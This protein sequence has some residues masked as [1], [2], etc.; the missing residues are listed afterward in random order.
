ME[1]TPAVLMGLLAEILQPL[2]SLVAI[3]AGGLWTYLIYRERRQKYPRAQLS[4]MITPVRLSPDKVLFQINLGIANTG[5]VL[6]SVVYGE[7]RVYK[8]RPPEKVVLDA[9][10]RTSGDTGGTSREPPWPQLAHWEYK[11]DKGDVEMEPGETDLLADFFVADSPVETLKVYSFIRNEA[12]KGRNIGWRLTTIR[13]V[14][15]PDEVS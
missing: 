11:C 8:L 5:K 14:D 6:L 1:L 4:H 12:K 13:D 3:G 15:V 2:A 9:L 7:T 10:T